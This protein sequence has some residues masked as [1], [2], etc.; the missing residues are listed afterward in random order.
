VKAGKRLAKMWGSAELFR[1]VGQIPPY[2]LFAL[3]V[4]IVLSSLAE[5]LGILLLVPLIGLLSGNSIATGTLPEPA[6]AL[7]TSS[8]ALLLAGFAM[9]LIVRSLL[10]QWQQNEAA[11]LQRKLIEDLRLSTMRA[12]LN[13]E[14]RWLSAQRISDNSSVLLS[15]LARLGWG[16]GQ[17]PSLVGAAI[18]I[19]VYLTVSFVL[20][21]PATLL[22]LAFGLIAYGAAAPYR[23]RIVVLG[24]AIGSSNSAL[25]RQIEETLAGAKL[26]KSLGKE[27][28]RIA[29]LGDVLATLES[30]H[31]QVV[32][33]AGKAR[34]LI[35]TTSAVFLALLTYGALNWLHVP[36]ERLL[37]LIIVFARFVPLLAGAQQGMLHWLNAVPALRSVTKV[38]DDAAVRAEPT[39]S[40]SSISVATAI[41]IDTASFT[42]PGSER[43]ALANASLTLPAPSTSAI[44]GPSGAGKSTLADLFGGLIEPDTGRLL[45]DGVAIGGATCVQWRQ[46]VAYVHQDAFFFDGSI[47]ENL[48]LASPGASDDDLHRAL[49]RA[50]ARFVEDLP[51]GLGT[52]MG[53]GG[54]RFSGGE[55]QRLALARALLASPALL[56]LDEATSALDPETEAAVVATIE[57]LRGS[58]TII[59]ISHR[60]ICGLTIDQHVVLDVSSSTAVQ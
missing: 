31:R 28:T 4:L 7:A 51:E 42:Y 56:I 23:R 59:V 57:A 36:A 44:T 9:L 3:L 6:V 25:H 13:A 19:A 47:A 26:I 35:D 11:A 14:W 49:T 52:R 43:P 2:R 8:P 34:T 50:A 55:R 18:S 29:G 27:Q 12:I 48:R 21:W 46:S 41:T 17:I 33:N 58:T 53:T 16:I 1:L 39:A 37:P 10:Q 60:P 40:G 54:K 22:A 15:D 38:I 20:S 24:E 45:I 32:A 30:Q 5:G